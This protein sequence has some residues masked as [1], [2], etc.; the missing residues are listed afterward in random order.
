MNVSKCIKTSSVF[1]GTLIGA[2]FATGREILVFFGQSNPIVPIL[3]AI[4]CGGFCALFLIAGKK[5]LNVVPN[6]GG[7]VMIGAFYIATFI[8]FSAM[9]SAGNNLIEE[10]LGI[11][12]GGIYAI[13]IIAIICLLYDNG[14]KILNTLVVPLLIILLFILSSRLEVSDLPN[15]FNIQNAFAYA[16][17]N[18]FL[19]GFLVVADGKDMNKNEI[20]LSATIT[21]IVL[22]LIILMV[23]IIVLNSHNAIMPVMDVAKALGFKVLS[24]IIIML[25]IITTLA[26]SFSAL[27]AINNLK[28]NNKMYSGFFVVLK[29]ALASLLGFKTIV[30]VGY[31]FVSIVGVIY[32]IVLISIVVKDRN[33]SQIVLINKGEK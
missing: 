28:F 29:G 11:K 15:K 9:I 2:G 24:S 3:S 13:I 33:Y 25:A 20:I 17:L 19:G 32:T 27:T 31:P 12:F 14:L 5:G 1:I 4:I 18:M 22:V 10:T 6:T 21:S 30:D 16:G 26:G 23:Y 8:I 7:R